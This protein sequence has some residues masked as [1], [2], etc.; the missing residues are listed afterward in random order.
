MGAFEKVHSGI[1]SLDDLLDYIRLGD[2]VVFQVGDLDEYAFFARRFAE[3]SRQDGRRLVY[4]RFAQHEPLL[5]GQEAFRYTLDP[6]VGFESFT[7]AVHRIVEQEGSEVLYVFDCL[8]ELQVAWA[9]DLMMGNFFCVT[10]PYLFQLDTVAFFPV[11]RGDHSYSAIARI[12]ETTQLFLDV[13]SS[14]PVI[15][16][17]PIKVWQRSS[18]NMFM[19]YR[20]DEARTRFGVLTDAT[21]ISRY[22]QVVEGSVTDEDLDLDSWERH[23]QKCRSLPPEDDSR[24]R[25]E[26]CRMLMTGDMKIRDLFDRYYTKEDY[27]RVEDRMIG[28]GRIGGKA[29]GMLLARKIIETELPDFLPRA[30]AHDSFYIG[31]HV[32][33]TFLVYNDLWGLRIEQKGDEGY[34]TLAEKMSQGM[35][36]GTFPKS[37]HEKFQRMLEYFGQSP[38]IVRSSSLLE[39]GFGNAFAGKYESVFCVNRGTPAERLQSFEN[40][41]RRV[42]ASTMNPSALAYRAARGLKDKDEQMSI[43]VQRV[44]GS[45]R[46]DLLY[47]SAAGVGYSYDPYNW[48]RD[49]DPLRGMLR[50]VCGLGTRAVDRTGVD[51]PRVIHIDRPLLT[52]TTDLDEQVRFSQHYADALDLRG[53]KLVHVP[54]ERFLPS[55]SETYRDY[56]CERDRAAERRLAAMGKHRDIWFGTCHGFTQN[57]AFLSDMER[58]LAAL[59]KAYDYPVDIEFT[60]NLAPDG[61]YMICLLQCRPLQVLRNSNHVELPGP[62][63]LDMLFESCGT[64]M[65]VSQKRTIDTVVVVDAKAY[66]ELPYREK[67]EIVRTV[68]DVNA[69]CRADARSAMLLSP[70]RV[71]TSSPELGVPLAFSDL[72][73]FSVIVEYDDAESGF[74]PELS[75][76][77]H[78]FQDLVESGIFYTALFSSGTKKATFDMDVLSRRDGE[79]P[80]MIMPE[81][82]HDVVHVYDTTGKGLTLYYDMM[83]GRTVCGFE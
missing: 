11:L 6:N 34:F 46:G 42:Y 81:K 80:E 22:Y 60:V 15:Y 32:F 67:S 39:D 5:D 54:L 7:V 66:H 63:Q 72:S 30:E 82:F 9:A 38:I 13:Y 14:G 43:L 17:H 52:T 51:Y 44:S 23:F 58:I 57:E 35:L 77:S 18:E 31:D 50:M 55:A 45:V 20:T 62:D 71:G 75:F 83:S 8:S 1:E 3:Q 25:S 56:V 29:C 33:Y 26:F 4:I 76:G 16:L 12:R 68:S 79:K 47:P 73:Q 53:N 40:A 19:P 27:L 59:Q 78:M 74:L 65:G 41:V 61:T 69:A 10:C 28:T 24:V 49:V 64:S 36:A 70:G 37:I 21:D 2:N 48:D